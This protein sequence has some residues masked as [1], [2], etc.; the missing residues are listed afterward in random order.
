MDHSKEPWYEDRGF[1]FDAEG[2]V[3][4]AVLE[5]ANLAR[6]MACIAACLGVSTEELATIAAWKDTIKDN[7]EAEAVT[8][9]VNRGYKVTTPSGEPA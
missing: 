5:P 9:L 6:I 3:V 7:A 4:G 1:L 8:F 2:V